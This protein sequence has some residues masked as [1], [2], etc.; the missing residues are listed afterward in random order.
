M[1]TNLDLILTDILSKLCD[2]DKDLFSGKT[3]HQYGA[4]AEH[5]FARWVRNT[6]D[7]WHTSPLTAVWRE[8]PDTRVI[9]EGVDHSYYH[10]DAVSARIVAKVK[11][12]LSFFPGRRV[13]IY[14]RHEF[15]RS[16]DGEYE[17]VKR[18]KSGLIEVCDPTYR[19]T[20]YTVTEREIEL[21]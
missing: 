9:K 1:L 18:T 13:N 2:E 7:L 14:Q 20:R 11:H 3:T 15:G 17:I 5:D 19:K 6:Y 4:L 16:L 10:P 21:T 12:H 8:N